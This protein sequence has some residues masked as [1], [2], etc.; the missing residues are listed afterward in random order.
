MGIRQIGDQAPGLC[1]IKQGMIRFPFKQTEHDSFFRGSQRWLHY[2]IGVS[3][4]KP[5]KTCQERF[6][7]NASLRQ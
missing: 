7:E 1:Q 2:I 6:F 4:H 5:A 3:E